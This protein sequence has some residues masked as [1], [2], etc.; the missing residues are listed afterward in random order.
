[1]NERMKS[2]VWM[3]FAALCMA[4]AVNAKDI[5]TVVFKTSPE[6]QCANCENKIKSNLRFEKGVKE[7]VTNLTTKEVTIT[8]DADKTTVDN[9]IAGFAKIKYTAT[10]ATGKACD[11]SNCCKE[12]KGEC[13]S[14]SCCAAKKQ[15]ACCKDKAK[16]GKAP[17]CKDKA[18]DGK[19]SC[20][21]QGEKK[22]QKVDGQSGATKK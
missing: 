19:S 14:D 7:I 15:G 13:K 5:K 11:K 22:A 4:L 8:Y 9:L 18:K 21:K 20:C 16:D 2:K 12:K 17:C 3:L 1:M 6:M 10:V